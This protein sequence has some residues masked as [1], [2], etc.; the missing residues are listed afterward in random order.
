MLP[1]GWGVSQ[2]ASR[3]RAAL[4]QSLFLSN[5][6]GFSR[7]MEIKYEILIHDTTSCIMNIC[8]FLNI[9]FHNRTLEFYRFSHDILPIHRRDWHPGITKPIYKHRSNIWGKCLTTD[10]IKIIERMCQDEM[11]NRGYDLSTFMNRCT[12]PSDK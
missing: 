6:I 1:W 9:P 5:V 7:I 12:I 10:E 3:W 11:L 4:A 2:V 8:N